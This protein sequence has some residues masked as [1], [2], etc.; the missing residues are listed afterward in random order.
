MV[1]KS[2]VR[3][4][5]VWING[6]YVGAWRLSTRKDEVLQ[7]DQKW[8]DSAEGRA[9][10]LSLPFSLENTP[11]VGRNVHNYFDNLLPDSD[12]IRRRLRQKFNTDSEDAFDLLAAIGRDCVGA[13]QLLP[14]NEVPKDIHQI[15]AEPLTD[16]EIAAALRQAMSPRHQLGTDDDFRISIAG[17]Q[18]KSAFT[19]H[20]GR[21]CK[22]KGTTPTTHIFKM[23]LGLVANIEADMTLSVENEW[24]CSKILA[25]YGLPIANCEMATFEK[26][27][28][29]IVER[30]DRQKDP[31]KRYWVRLVQE[32]FCQVLG[33]SSANK[34]EA[35]GGPGVDDLAKVLRASE[36]SEQDIE[37][38]FKSQILFWMLAAGDGHAKNFSIRL[39]PKGRFQMTPL[40][41]V[42]SY[43]PI[44][45]EA[46]N[47]V[48]PFNLKMAMA[49]R[50][51]NKHYKRREI[52]RRHYNQT[53]A[54]MGLREKSD[55]FIQELLAKTPDVIAAIQKEVPDNFP[56]GV[57]DTVL[58]GIRGAARE[59]ETMEP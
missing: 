13:I 35:D 21:W 36:N 24:L 43:W 26:Q 22:P 9:L 41:D 2:T 39:L 47:K 58:G 6:S 31:S 45:G 10:S 5:G 20:D 52:L 16:A 27:R 18:E 14:P 4:L 44:L 34:Y 53:G 8:I 48:S 28:T 56:A 25:A 1:R 55:R 49:A 23:P 12:P 54:R 19:R 7:Y 30:F 37:T 32:D 50:G 59:L 51:K 15:N 17:A 33:I 11:H 42:L 3:E 38:L 46:P 40:Y 57:L 29:L